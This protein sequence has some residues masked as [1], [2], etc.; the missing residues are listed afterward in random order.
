[1]GAPDQSCSPRA[2]PDP[3]ATKPDTPAPDLSP[4]DTCP[5]N[6][7]TSPHATIEDP[8]GTVPEPWRQPRA[9]SILIGWPTVPGYEILGELGRGGMGIVYKARHLQLNRV[10]A[11]KMLLGGPQAGPEEVVR[12]LAEAEAIARVRHPHI[13][14]VYAVGKHEGVPY[15]A[16]EY[17]EGGSL[18]KKLHGLPLAANEQ[19]R[20]VATLARAIEHAHQAGI[21]HRDLKPANVLLAVGS[22][23]WVVGS[24]E[25]SS[26]S[27]PAAQCP[28]LMVPKI[29]D[30]GLA[31]RVEGGGGLTKTGDV[32]GTPA[33][34]APEQARGKIQE[35]SPA[36]DIYALGAIIYELLAG[37]PPFRGETVFET[38]EQVCSQD[39]VPPSAMQ[40]NVPRDLE[41][42]C[43]KCLQKQARQRYPSA[44]ALADDLERFLNGKPIRAR[45]VGLGERAWKWARRNPV[46]AALLTLLVVGLVAGTLFSFLVWRESANQYEM[47]AVQGTALHAQTLSILHEQYATDVVIPMMAQ[48]VSAKHDFDDKEGTLPLPG[49][50]VKELGRRVHRG[51]AGADVRLYSDYPFP[52]RIGDNPLD[53]FETEALEELRRNPDE[54]YY[55]F[56]EID[57][58]PLLR[59][60]VASRM[61][62]GCIDCHN[63]HP[64]TP[65]RDWQIG[66]VRGV[67][68]IIH[69]LD[70]K[71]AQTR[72]RLRWL[73]L[74]PVTLIGLSL[75]AGVAF[76]VMRRMR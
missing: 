22:G 37:R 59:Y 44:A 5:S 1:M 17:L 9:Q 48:G 62:Q 26:S 7:G 35:I 6:D 38:L 12:F 32:M 34:M 27:P 43:L 66:D 60:A 64:D 54:P 46:V 67:L 40:R 3:L 20:L 55:R 57:G 41:T 51:R 8:Y 16:L 25:K 2:S 39:P 68:E 21:V 69:P 56:D 33:Y 29:T 53:R 74:I 13:V 61:K 19:A 70:R 73:F 49:T 50:M 10:V 14:Q 15:I 18:D 42:I 58:V 63:T 45:P 30:F 4:V 31:R 23:E 11:L 65:K 71:V 36:V 24:N 52:W 75:A 28:L 76:L 72:S 47:I